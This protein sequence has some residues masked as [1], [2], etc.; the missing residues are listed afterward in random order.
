MLSPGARRRLSKEEDMLKDSTGDERKLF[1]AC[2]RGPKENRNYKVWDIYFTLGGDSLYAGRILKAVMEFPDCYP[3]QPPTLKFV[4]KMFHPNIYEDGKMC[5]SILEEDTH[6]PTGYGDSKDKWAPVQNIRTI[7][8]SIIVILNAPNTSSPANV[9][10]SVMHRD[11]PEEYA[12]K[13]IKIAREE[14]EKLR[15]TDPQA[16]EIA[17]EMEAED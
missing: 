9:D 7:L 14:D 12:K 11:N 2:P 1:R 4:S 6:D 17:L 3:L 15:S 8:L 16:R 10:A 13:V 5:I